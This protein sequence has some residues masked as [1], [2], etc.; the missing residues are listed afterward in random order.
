MAKGYKK[1]GGERFKNNLIN[2]LSNQTVE[3][4]FARIANSTYGN[5]IN[6][7]ISK[8]DADFLK[9]MFNAVDNA[10]GEEQI[11]DKFYQYLIERSNTLINDF[12][13]DFNTYRNW[14][15]NNLTL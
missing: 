7:T 1:W 14:I 9:D 2:Y 8:E 11:I 12:K 3:E 13:Q 15:L 10:M 4:T 5:Y 6:K